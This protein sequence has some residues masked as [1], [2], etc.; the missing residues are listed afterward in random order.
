MQITFKDGSF[1][2][3]N[4]DVNPGKISVIVC[5]MKNPKEVTMSTLELDE[6]QAQEMQE[7]LSKWLKDNQQT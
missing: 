6:E 4:S 5:G 3:L 7:F 1:I 2:A